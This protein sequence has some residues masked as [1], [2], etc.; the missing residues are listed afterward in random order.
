M[1]SAKSYLMPRLGSVNLRHLMFVSYT[2]VHKTQYLA[3]F[4]TS[5]DF[6][7][8]KKINYQLLLTW[9]LLLPIELVLTWRIEA[10]NKVNSLLLSDAKWQHRSGSTLA[11]VMACCLKAPSHYLNQCWHIICRVLWHSPKRHCTEEMK[12]NAICTPPLY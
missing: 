4:K 6:R 9:Y 2:G 3:N 8:Y 11:Q 5:C 1:T 10:E 7:W 12:W